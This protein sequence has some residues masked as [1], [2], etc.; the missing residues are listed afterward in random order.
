MKKSVA[1]LAAF[2]VIVFCLTEMCFWTVDDILYQYFVMPVLNQY[3]AEPIT[4]L[5][6]VIQSQ[7]NHIFSKN[8]RVVAH[9]I[10][11]IFAALL[12]KHIFAICN[13]LVYCLLVFLIL[14]VA[15]VSCRN[16]FALLTAIGMCL[17]GLIE[18]YVPSTFVGYFYMP[19]IVL[20][21]LLLLRNMRR[22]FSFPMAMLLF[23][24]S[25]ITGNSHEGYTIPISA[26]LGIFLVLYR[27]EWNALQVVMI[28]GFWS[29]ILFTALTPGSQAMHGEDFTPNYLQTPITL[30]CNMR[31]FYVMLVTLAVLRIKKM[32]SLRQILL[33]RE[34]LFWVI[35][36]VSMIPFSIWIF[37]WF[38]WRQLFCVELASIIITLRVLPKHAL[39]KWVLAVLFVGVGVLY[40]YFVGLNTKRSDT[41]EE[42]VDLYAQ[43]TDGVVYYDITTPQYYPENSLSP[44][45]FYRCTFDEMNGEVIA[46]HPGAPPMTVLP[47]CCRDLTAETPSQAVRMDDGACVFLN[48]KQHPASKF[49]ITLTR[50][51]G[52]YHG[53]GG[54]YYVDLKNELFYFDLPTH[55]VAVVYAPNN[56]FVIMLDCGIV[57]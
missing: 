57:P 32:V 44:R 40:G 24:I 30:L 2:A 42:I 47:V 51:V 9:S 8:G 17:L 49:Y 39:P 6:D 50:S 5:G 52:F 23:C 36:M 41:L 38:G 34:N 18:K 14:R 7:Y 20:A 13:G 56:P 1:I 31:C 45:L 55:E 3:S 15:R 26:A 12:G 54:R 11:Q 33:D 29:G 37:G 27:H 4:S 16:P 46:R 19:V 48:N 53:A 22:K 10:V 43:S 35:A 28:L 21:W 25:V